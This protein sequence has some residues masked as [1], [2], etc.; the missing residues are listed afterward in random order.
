MAR[1]SHFYLKKYLINYILVI[2][3]EDMKKAITCLL[4]FFIGIFYINATDTEIECKYELSYGNYKDNV[5]FYLDT[6]KGLQNKFKIE[7]TKSTG[8][9]DSALGGSKGNG[10]IFG[11]KQIYFDSYDTMQK[12][13]MNDN[14]TPLQ[15]CPDDLQPFQF[16]KPQS[17]MFNTD[18]Y[19]LVNMNYWPEMNLDGKGTIKR[20]KTNT[21][22]GSQ[23]EKCYCCGSSSRGC[24]YYWTNKPGS[25]CALT[26]KPKEECTGT[27]ADDEKRVKKLCGEPF[28]FSAYGRNDASDSKGYSIM[29][30]Y[31]TQNGNK[32]I[33]LNLKKGT[34]EIESHSHMLSSEPGAVLD[35]D[36][37][38]NKYG[39][40]T[41]RIESFDKCEDVG[42]TYTC[43]VDSGAGGKML[44]VGQDCS[45]DENADPDTKH[46]TETKN[47]YETNYGNKHSGG[48]NAS[49]PTLDGFGDPNATCA[50]VLGPTLT[51]LV[52]EAIKWVRIAGAII[53][54]VNGM[55]KLIPAIMSKDAEALNKAIKTCIT[56]A[57]ILV[58]CVLFSWLLNLIGTLFKW[59]V[60]CIV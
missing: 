52:K 19:Y 34:E 20:I 55:L 3:G 9:F 32:Y 43:D 49:E 37:F 4:M 23:G 30:Q 39:T 48:G 11:D 33:E 29:G 47:E 41:I 18:G 21:E 42:K 8:T 59:D 54:I 40:N 50:D 45:N 31:Y 28:V 2:V 36:Y 12:A 5:I 13:F 35:T 16:G 44:Y 58:F 14:R 46:E 27:T 57:I 22:T 17:N 60:S 25:T 56:M 51:A 53:A 7:G 38:K 10:T 6:K 24:T 26:K 15:S 1:L